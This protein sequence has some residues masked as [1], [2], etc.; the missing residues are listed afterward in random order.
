MIDDHELPP[1]EII[2]MKEIADNNKFTIVGAQN[3]IIYYRIYII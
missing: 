3:S 2:I 1:E